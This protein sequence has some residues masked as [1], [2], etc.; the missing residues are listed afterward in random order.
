LQP[1]SIRVRLLLIM[2]Q[3]ATAP[4]DLWTPRRVILA[5]LTVLLVAFGFYLL[6]RFRLIFF[7]LFTAIVL[8]T[9]LNP[10]VA[11]LMRW[12]IPR[13]IA[14]ILI[15]LLL[16]VLVIAFL[17]VVAPIILEQT[18][19][20]TTLVGNWY[21]EIYRSLLQSP[22]LLVRRIVRQLPVS[23]PLTLP[24]PASTQEVDPLILVEQTISFGGAIL[25]NFLIVAATALLAGMW[26]LESE[27][28]SRIFILALPMNIRTPVRDFLAEAGE[29]VGAYTR[30]LALLVLIVGVFSTIAYFIIGL[31]NVLVLGLLA[32][33]F[34][35]VPL[36][37]PL[38]GAIPALLVATSLGPD[39]V[40]QVIIATFIIQTLENNIIV[41]RLM[42]RAVGV[43][44]I[45]SFL[46]FLTF[47]SLFGFVGALLAVPLAAVIQITLQRLLFQ[48]PAGEQAPLV[49]RDAVSMLRYEAQDLVQDVRKLV[50]EKDAEVESSADR[51]ED[52]IESVVQDL[53]SI[54]AEIELK[55]ANASNGGGNEIPPDRG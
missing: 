15:A 2:E 44:P 31:P 5:T 45:A 47:G 10:L 27:R 53:D 20:L 40:L 49:N 35:L 39:V 12:K 18:A 19:T 21:Q 14:V 16:L 30:G 33:I 3:N 38:L 36:V 48:A 32:G 52:S 41:P 50:R 37:G 46:A 28:L 11:L 29:K 25:Q 4:A 54:L 6:V 22:S 34:E 51:I 55:Q 23:L 17:L 42:D 26:I 1:P 8:S 7:L 13:T 9:A 24:S 43:N